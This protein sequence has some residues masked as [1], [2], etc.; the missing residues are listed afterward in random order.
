MM[1]YS[2]NSLLRSFSANPFDFLALPAGS[3]CTGA[4]EKTIRI[5]QNQLKTEST[6]IYV[7][8]YEHHSNILP[9]IQFFGN[10]NALACDD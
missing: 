4:I 6:A 3:G 7:S 10:V 2:Q 5:L 1:N 9:W 8:P